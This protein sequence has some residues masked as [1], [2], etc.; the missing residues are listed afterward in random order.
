M[1]G[2]ETTEWIRSAARDGLQTCEVADPLLPIEIPDGGAVL[3]RYIDL[4]KLLSLVGNEVLYFSSL[5]RLGDKFEGQWSRRTIQMIHDWD[6]LWMGE[7][8]NRCFIEDKVKNQ[9]LYFPK[10]HQQPLPKD[11]SGHLGRLIRD[12]DHQNQ[13]FVSCWYQE[14]GES[15]AMWK[16]FAGDKYGIAVRTTAS[17]L[18][19][20][21]TNRL[22]DY[23]GFV[24]YLD[25]EREP[26][27]VS[28]F[29][30]VFY[31]RKEFQ[32]EREVR[33]VLAPQQRIEKPE[34]KIESPG[35]PEPIN[36]TYLIE[37]LIV[38]PY[39]PDWLMEV[40]ELLIA[41]FKMEVAV[42]KSTL[43]REPPAK[44]VWAT[45]R[46][47]KAYFTFQDGNVTPLR[48]WALSRDQARRVACARWNLE[49]PSDQSI[50]V[51][52][53]GECNK[54]F[55]Q[56]PEEYERVANPYINDFQ[57]SR[58]PEDGLDPT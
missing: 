26:M 57:K 34:N 1:W 31:K 22:P 29:P 52:R 6:E 51:W 15:Q 33:A 10:E 28:H 8:V 21:F 17:K 2:F 58:D 47:L 41:R 40:V 32:H 27:A 50:E 39:S 36:P 56:R 16:L 37:E 19:G 46:N 23:L 43:E 24:K 13:T 44:S 30:P 4:A 12:R 55:S 7:D 42:T 3:W 25:Y 18:I 35:I 49:Y 45:V 54:R 14:D 48:I 9:R 20:S 11:T 38:S 53:E 5:A